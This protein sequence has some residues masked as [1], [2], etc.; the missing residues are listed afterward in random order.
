VCC[1]AICAAS[2]VQLVCV[3]PVLLRV[4]SSKAA[5]TP[6]MIHPEVA[7]ATRQVGLLAGLGGCRSSVVTCVCPAGRSQGHS[8]QVVLGQTGEAMSAYCIVAAWR[9]GCA[10]DD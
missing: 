10:L 3:G 2:S 4:L 1:V 5:M 6:R 7:V 8:V 9:D